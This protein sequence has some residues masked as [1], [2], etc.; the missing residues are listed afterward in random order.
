MRLAN[1]TLWPI[2]ITLDVT[3]EFAKKLDPRIEP[4]CSARSRRRHARRLHV[5]DVWQPDRKAEAK[6]VFNSTSTAHPGADYAINKSNP[7][8]V[9]GRI[10]EFQ[11]PS[12]Y[13]FRSLRLTPAEL[14][15]EFTRLG[16]T[17][18][19]AFQTRNP[20]HRAHV[21]LTMR[22]AKQVEANLLIHPSVGMTKPGDV[23]LFHPHPLLRAAAAE[24]SARHGEALHAAARHAYGRP[25]RGDLARPDSQESRLHALH[26]RPRSRRSRQGQRRQA[27]LRTL[28]CTGNLQEA[29]GGNGRRHGSLPDDG[30]P[31]R[32]RP[33]RSRR[34]SS[35]GSEGPRHFRNRTAPAPQRRPR[36]S[37]MVHVSRKS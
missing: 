36:D 10:E 29:R 11:P 13:D 31:A 16:W 37:R 32:R 23:D 22:A 15:A 14:R 26:R 27:F 17:S 19:V 34:R 4:C 33:L 3:E 6:A 24:I 9:G 25:A 12:H 7:W 8:Y 1:G 20:M 5:E 30:L 35:E 2:P 18:V 28:R 21:E